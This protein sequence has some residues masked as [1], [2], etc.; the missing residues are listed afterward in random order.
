ML[1]LDYGVEKFQIQNIPSL[2]A[3]T[4]SDSSVQ[5]TYNNFMIIDEALRGEFIS[6]YQSGK[7]DYYQMQDLIKA[8]KNFLYYGEK[9][10]DY[11]SEYEKNSRDT[12]IQNAIISSYSSMRTNYIRVKALVAKK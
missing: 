4:F 5:S 3:K 9:T 7:I 1:E 10:F 11:I 12:Q 2:S 8:Y 6:Q